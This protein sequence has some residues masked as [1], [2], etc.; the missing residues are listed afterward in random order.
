[1]STSPKP[2]RD[3]RLATSNSSEGLAQRPIVKDDQLR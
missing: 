3:R 1:L 2:L